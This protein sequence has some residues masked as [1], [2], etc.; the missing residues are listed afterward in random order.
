M[1]N[2]QIALFQEYILTRAVF[3]NKSD[4]KVYAPALKAHEVRL[5]VAMAAQRGAHTQH[6]N[7]RMT[8]LRPSDKEK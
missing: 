1:G 5:L 3:I 2:Q 7:T 6:R 4:L 8:H